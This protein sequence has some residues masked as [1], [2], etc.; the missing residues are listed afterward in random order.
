[1]NKSYLEQL[2]VYRALAALSVCAVHFT[3]DTVFTKYFAQGLFVQLFFTLSGFVICLNYI[4][5][6]QKFINCYDKDI[7]CFS[8]TNGSTIF[9]NNVK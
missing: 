2:D 1:M 9:S 5:K 4:E 6:L 8:A 7:E 3:Y